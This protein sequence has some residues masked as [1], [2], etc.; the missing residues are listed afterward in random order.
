MKGDGSSWNLAQVPV[1]ATYWELADITV[2]ATA[3]VPEN[4]FMPHTMPTKTSSDMYVKDLRG[5]IRKP[6]R[7][8]E[9]SH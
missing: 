8:L 5:K 7:F 2:M 9:Y 3:P 6:K 1:P 4:E